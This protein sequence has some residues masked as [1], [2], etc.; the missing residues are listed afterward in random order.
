MQMR[1]QATRSEKLSEL[2]GVH[3]GD[4]SLGGVDNVRFTRLLGNALGVDFDT[5][6]LGFS[7]EFV[8]GANTFDESLTGGRFADV[9]NADVDALGD[10]ASVNSLVDDDTEGVLG[11]VENLASL[12]V[13]ELVGHTALVATVADNVNDVVLFEYGEQL[14]DWGG[15][16]SLK[17]C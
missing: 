2:D 5:S 13:V 12:S 6:D 3:V 14:G 8:V 10:D 17:C 1:E 15:A 9:L 7:L 4:A 16:V 11:H